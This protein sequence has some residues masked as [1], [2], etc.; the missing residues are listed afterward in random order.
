MSAHFNSEGRTVAD[1]SVMI[2]DKCWK[3]EAILKKIRESRWISTLE[4]S[5]PSVMH[6][7]TDGL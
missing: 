7:R 1:L 6:L 5:W 3:E 4:T 2:I